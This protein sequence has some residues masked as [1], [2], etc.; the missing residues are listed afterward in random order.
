MTEI[1]SVKNA[2][3]LCVQKTSKE[4]LISYSGGICSSSPLCVP[5]TTKAEKWKQVFV[6]LIY[7]RKPSALCDLHVWK[8]MAANTALSFLV[9]IIKSSISYGFFVRQLLLCIRNFCTCNTP[10]IWLIEQHISH[11]TFCPCIQ[12]SSEV[13]ITHLFLLRTKDRNNSFNEHWKIRKQRH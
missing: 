11:S 5:T 6:L 10:L 3:Q 9:G 13:K 2:E 1:F 4:I 12:M 7:A 8:K